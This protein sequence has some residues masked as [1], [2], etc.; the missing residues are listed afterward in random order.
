MI[1]IEKERILK[2]EDDLFKC[3]MFSLKNDGDKDH[4]QKCAK[5]ILRRQQS[6]LANYND[7]VCLDIDTDQSD[8]NN[9]K[10]TITSPEQK[11]VHM[12]RYN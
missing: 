10:I 4:I 2:I 3:K 12:Y 5:R 7:I 1:R 6:E 8:N 9:K 11:N